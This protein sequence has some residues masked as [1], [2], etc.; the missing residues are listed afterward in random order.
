MDR[1]NTVRHQVDDFLT[2]G[3]GERAFGR[4][5]KSGVLAPTANYQID[6]VE[7]ENITGNDRQ[8]TLQLVLRRTR[9]S[10]NGAKHR[11]GHACRVHGLCQCCHGV[12]AC[13]CEQDAAHPQRLGSR[14]G[15]HR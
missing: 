4:R 10:P 3:N 14:A 8:L 15:G 7:I 6:H 2:P 12:D 5:H 13:T 9:Q 1:P 11:G